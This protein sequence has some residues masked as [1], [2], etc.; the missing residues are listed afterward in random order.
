[1]VLEDAQLLAHHRL[2]RLARTHELG[3]IAG[4]LDIEEVQDA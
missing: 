1:M 4:S 3:D 2:L